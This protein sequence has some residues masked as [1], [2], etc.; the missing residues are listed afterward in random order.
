[1]YGS[2]SSEVEIKIKDT[3]IKALAIKNIQEL[4]LWIYNTGKKPRYIGILNKS[5]IKSVNLVKLK[6]IPKRLQELTKIQGRVLDCNTFDILTKYLQIKSRFYEIDMIDERK[7]IQDARR[8]SKNK[9]KE[10][11]IMPKIEKEEKQNEI[12][13]IAEEQM[14]LDNIFEELLDLNIINE[15]TINDFIIKNYE[16]VYLEEQLFV[17]STEN[18]K[19]SFQDFDEFTGISKYFLI[20]IDC[21]MIQCEEGFEL[22]RVSILD[23][24]GNV[25]YDKIVKPEN[26]IKDYLT[27]Y[28]GLTKESFENA[29]SFSQMKDDLKEIIGTNTV[30]LGHG[31]FN[32]LNC[33]K[34]KHKKLID[35]TF[36]Y[37][38]KDNH[39]VS[40]KSLTKKYLKRI[41]QEDIHCSIED[42]R[43]CLE[44]LALKIHEIEDLKA[45]KNLLDF[46]CKLN[47]VDSGMDFKEKMNE[48]CI[49]F[50]HCEESEFFEMNLQ[51][52]YKNI[53]FLFFYEE[54]DKLY[55]MI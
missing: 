43:A 30:I 22:G 46:N 28:S 14:P 50:F 16:S 5:K 27:K 13:D 36:I 3:T 42:A 52:E 38:T 24:K 18:V 15:E 29:I 1:M 19:I 26:H 7:K 48:R 9:K 32:D 47:F 39:R 20:S 37:R 17:N 12:T 25:L 4:L 34:I 44:L 53:L 40:L 54:D 6:N 33:L 55:F 23:S 8:K 11:K 41:I 10:L 49:N 45:G 21:E 51:I 31:L 35:T 2:S